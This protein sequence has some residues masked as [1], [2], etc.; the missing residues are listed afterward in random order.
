MKSSK[1]SVTTEP[2]I[3][4]PGGPGPRTTVRA[5]IQQ[6]CRLHHQDLVP[7]GP[8]LLVPAGATV[9]GGA[10]GAAPLQRENIPLPGGAAFR[11]GLHQ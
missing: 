3:L 9:P 11:S 6:A 10:R 4:T 2:C 8:Q 5:A 1:N 7:P